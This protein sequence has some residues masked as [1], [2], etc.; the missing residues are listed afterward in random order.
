MTHGLF[1]FIW[2]KSYEIGR[3]PKVYFQSFWWS[4]RNFY[5]VSARYPDTGVGKEPMNF[6]QSLIEL[7]SL[8]AS[9]N[10]VPSQVASQDRQQ[11]SDV[12]EIEYAERICS[13]SEQGWGRISVCAWSLFAGALALFSIGKRSSTYQADIATMLY[14]SISCTR[15][16][17]IRRKICQLYSPLMQ[18]VF[19][20]LSATLAASLMMSQWITT[21]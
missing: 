2:F 20:M 6:P 15:D 14:V 17:S 12:R 1:Q 9:L 8:S 18:E 4:I 16:K 19:Y 21:Q 7:M 13:R 10:A 5:F 11:F 3:N